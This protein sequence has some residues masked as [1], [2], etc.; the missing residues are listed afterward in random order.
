MMQ[1]PSVFADGTPIQK[2]KQPLQKH[3]QFNE[4]VS[5]RVKYNPT[6]KL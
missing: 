3:D 6:E 5:A 4:L 1:K 2:F